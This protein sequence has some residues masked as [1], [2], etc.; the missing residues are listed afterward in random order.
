MIA[1]AVLWVRTEAI[2]YYESG[3]FFLFNEMLDLCVVFHFDIKR[4]IV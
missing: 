4:A 3:F 1:H 2:F